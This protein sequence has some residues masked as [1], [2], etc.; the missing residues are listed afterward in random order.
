MA[1]RISLSTCRNLIMMILTTAFIVTVSSCHSSQK[2]VKDSYRQQP[3][4]KY[5]QPED[6]RHDVARR[7][8]EIEQ[9]GRLISEAAKWIGTPYRYSRQSFDGT[10]CSGMIVE[11]YKKVFD[12]KLPR[13]SGEQQKYCKPIDRKDIRPG[14][15][16]FF[17]TG[18]DSRRVSHVGLYIGEGEMI[19]ASTSRGVIVSNLSERYYDNRFHSA[20]RAASIDKLYSNDKK[21]KSKTP[22]KSGTSDPLKSGQRPIATDSISVDRLLSVPITPADIDIDDIITEKIDSIFTDFLD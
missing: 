3:P 10:D 1:A 20:G 15:L 13:N 12:E 7:N 2:T 5:E 22:E 8:Y 9:I 4:R 18:N 6:M 16:L 17:A 14:D 19:H 11:L 21:R